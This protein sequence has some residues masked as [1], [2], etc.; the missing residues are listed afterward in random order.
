MTLVSLVLWRDWRFGL[1]ELASKVPNEKFY[2]Q[3]DWLAFRRM[4]LQKFRYCQVPGCDQKATQVD[5]KV[6]RRKGG[7][8]FDPFNSFACCA[9]H[10]SEKTA[11]F[12]MPG[13]KQSDMPVRARGCS[14][15]GRS[16][17]PLHPWNQTK[18]SR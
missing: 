3:A 6:S 2:K 15:D 16:L 11:R 5:H 18:N 10:H 13:R 12:D 7:A 14:V 1:R 4:I 8:P 9:S 17:D